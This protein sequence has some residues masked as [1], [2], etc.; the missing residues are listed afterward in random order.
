MTVAVR[1]PSE[2]TMTA[3]AAR[4]HDPVA[5]ANPGRAAEL[6]L[7]IFV[8]CYNEEAFIIGTIET[9]GAALAHVGG[10]SYEIIVIDDASHDRSAVLVQAHIASHPEDRILLRRNHANRGLAQNF[11]M[12]PSSA[13]ASTTGLSAATTPS[14]KTP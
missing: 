3:A 5:V 1:L 7:T 12:P 2:V 4:L 14:P 8:S 10:L 13:R 11:S 6:D 9:I